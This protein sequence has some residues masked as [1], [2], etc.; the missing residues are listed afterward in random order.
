M[1]VR[2]LPRGTLITPEEVAATVGWLCTPAASGITG[3]AIIV[4]GGDS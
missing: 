1:I 4:A 2:T 3:Q